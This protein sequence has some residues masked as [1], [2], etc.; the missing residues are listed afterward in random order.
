MSRTGIALAMQ[1]LVLR[2]V[3]LLIGPLVRLLYRTSRSGQR[4]VRRQGGV[5]VAFNHTSLLDPLLVSASIPRP[6]RYLAKEVVLGGRVGSFL[7]R[8]VFGQIALREAGS[9]EDALTDAIAVLERGRAIAIAPEG[10]RS[11]DG[12]IQRGRTGLARLAYATGAPIYPIAIRGAYEAWPRSRRRPRLFVPTSITVG[13]AIVVE[14]DATAFDDSRR[15]RMLT[16]EVMGAIAALL[17]K[18]YEPAQV[19]VAAPRQSA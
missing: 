15:C 18:A 5:I 19:D 7:L 13:D 4:S 17:G 3:W 14:R 1:E 16:D 10:A 2:A 6:L 12:E 9:N 8:H 11:F